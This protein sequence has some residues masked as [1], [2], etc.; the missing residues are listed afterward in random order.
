[1]TAQDKAP[2]HD[3]G[4]QSS[5]KGR[6][7]RG[8]LW[9]FGGYGAS[10][11]L[12]LGS[13]IVLTHLLFPEAFGLMAI[14]N[15]F[16]QGLVMFSDVGLG[17]SI[18][19]NR[20]GGKP[21]FLRT[22]WTIAILRGLLLAAI[23]AVIAWPVARFY[24]E[25]RLVL[26]LPITA[27]SAIIAG[28]NSTNL[29]ALMRTVKIA[30]LTIIDLSAQTLGI[31][32]MVH[33]AWRAPSIWALVVG[34]LATAYAKMLLSHTV[35]GAP[36]MRLEF[37][38]DLAREVLRFGK[39]IFLSTILGFIVNRVD[40]LVLAKFMSLGGL[41]V[42]SIAIMLSQSTV[43]ALRA[44]SNRVLFPVYAHFAREAPERL[45]SRTG[46]VRAALMAVTL[47]P[48]WILTVFGQEIVDLVYDPR[49]HEAGWMLQVL[50]AGA[51]PASICAPVGIVLLAVGNSF[52]HLL[53][54]ISRAG[55]LIAAMA[56]GGKMAGTPGLIVGFSA[57]PLLFYP[58][59]AALVRKYNVW[60]PLIDFI[61]LAVSALVV[62]LGLW[63]T[64]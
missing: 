49:Y 21:E 22:A 36:R 15:V 29:Y 51:I 55:L 48:L 34:G 26:F 63:L 41:G 5:L 33:W 27:F 64:S 24:D 47:P 59:L 39:W 40:R 42:Y 53:M 8:T 37:H 62:G 1:M 44:V 56:V 18:I 2:A 45:R 17:P 35:L 16:L 3:G 19:Q 38:P 31:A 4:W 57:S 43:E 6:A 46:R 52:R 7:L 25:P 23:A 28:F 11:V 13:N 12:R 50:A 30:K 32:I 54:L 14:V 61:G 58:F 20:R 9:T 10:Q 60:L